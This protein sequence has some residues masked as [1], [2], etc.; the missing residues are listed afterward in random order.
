MF[1]LLNFWIVSEDL[2]TRRKSGQEEEGRRRRH[3]RQ[4]APDPSIGCEKDGKW[5]WLEV[6]TTI[7][8]EHVLMNLFYNDATL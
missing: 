2:E 7:P 6:G 5:T 3:C 1:S 4:E 8:P